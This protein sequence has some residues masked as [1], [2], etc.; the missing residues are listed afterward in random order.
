MTASGLLIQQPGLMSAIIDAGRGIH[1]QRGFSES[2]PMDDDAFFWVNWLCANPEGTP[3][4]EW[5]GPAE[6]VATADIH[7]AVTGP[8]AKV[9]V[10]AGTQALWET[11]PLKEGDCLSVE[12]H[13]TG[14][15][16]Y[17]GIRGAWN[18]PRVAQSACTVAREKLG[19]L[20]ED[21]S[22][23]AAEDIIS[24]TADTPLT[25]LREVPAWG[26]PDYSSDIPIN[27]ILG[28]QSRWFSEVAK[29]LFFTS[30]YKITNKIDRMGY[31]LSGTPVKCARSEMHSEGITLGAVQCPPDGQP[32]VMMRDRQTLG[33]YPKLGCVS[34]VDLNRLAQSVPGEQVSFQPEDADDARASFLLRLSRRRAITGN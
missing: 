19:G 24:V 15:R 2:G 30:N 26:R 22:Y 5:V 8:G 17:I 32:I 12:P 31:R 10:N 21:G 9:S 27:V 4:I 18:V 3:A 33:G 34:P 20:H 6:F 7:V 14:T 16:H 1:Q 28:Y 25:T 29:Q 13:K 23:C 11:L